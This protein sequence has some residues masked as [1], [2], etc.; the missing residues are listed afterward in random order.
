MTE[1]LDELEALKGL[2]TLSTEG[3]T[4]ERE[5]EALPG[6]A[7]NPLTQLGNCPT[8]GTEPCNSG[9][10][11]G[12]DSHNDALKAQ[13]IQVDSH[14]GNPDVA[15]LA[16]HNH[17]PAET[18]TL[19]KEKKG[20]LARDITLEPDLSPSLLKTDSSQVSKIC[21]GLSSAKGPT[22]TSFEDTHINNFSPSESL[23]VRDSFTQ[24]NCATF[25]PTVDFY[26]WENRRLACNG[27]GVH[28]QCGYPSLPGGVYG[29]WEGKIDSPLIGDNMD[30][31]SYETKLLAD[32]FTN[33]SHAS[34]A[35][36]PVKTVNFATQTRSPSIKPSS[37]QINKIPRSFRAK[38]E[39]QTIG[40]LPVNTEDQQQNKQFWDQQSPRRTESA[41]GNNTPAQE[42]EIYSHFDSKSTTPRACDKTHDGL[43]SSR[44][45][46]ILSDSG[47]SSSIPSAIYHSAKPFTNR[48]QQQRA[49]SSMAAVNS[50]PL[51]TVTSRPVSG[52]QDLESPHSTS[53]GPTLKVEYVT[54]VWDAYISDFLVASDH[55]KDA[56]IFD[57]ATATCIAS[58]FDFLISR[59]EFKQ[60]NFCL[61]K[62]NIHAFLKK[63][64]RIFYNI[65]KYSI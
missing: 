55:I 17:E 38:D 11:T 54:K 39:F 19:N 58:S 4:G 52:S 23:K 30:L 48:M 33:T 7:C 56:A 62:Q 51:S 40:D 32:S 37:L 1:K 31:S 20:D 24:T 35:A 5:Q 36:K 14:T 8:R 60:V 6:G 43:D 2:V 28:G 12:A 53:E 3:P 45:T 42:A 29:C 18:S 64:V 16:Q 26:L 21:N 59:E 41:P 47:T 46:S 10:G 9:E 13:G 44:S 34:T 65:N 50:D 61:R 15:G 49:A 57:R 63:F 27:W 22:S 25:P